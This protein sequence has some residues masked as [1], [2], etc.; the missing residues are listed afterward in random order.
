MPKKKPENCWTCRLRRKKC[1]GTVPVC[2]VCANLGIS[3][4]YSETQPE[5]MDGGSRQKAE[6]QR[7]KFEVKSR[8]SQ[9][10]KEK[11]IRRIQSELLPCSSQDEF[12]PRASLA[13]ATA[14][15]PE[16]HSQSASA[17]ENSSALWL[18]NS[19]GDYEIGLAVAFMDHAFPLL[20]PFYQPAV[21]DGSRA[22][23]LAM[24]MKDRTFRLQT[25]AI[26]S[27]LL[28]VIPCRSETI[29][30]TCK[31][32]ALEGA[33]RARDLATAHFQAD[34]AILIT[35]NIH[36]NISDTASLLINM[37]SALDLERV[38][39]DGDEWQVHLQA[40]LD[41]LRDLLRDDSGLQASS[42]PLILGQ[43]SDASI[44]VGSNMWSVEQAAFRFSVAK[45]V[46][47][48]IVASS[49]L[50]RPPSLLS[51][52]QELLR[53]DRDL[54][55]RNP[56]N[57]ADVNGCQNW[58]M[59]LLGEVVALGAWKKE[60]AHTRYGVRL[61]LRA[62]ELRKRL[63]SGL[64]QLDQSPASPT[65]L[66][67]DT[68]TARSSP[69]TSLVTKLWAYATLALLY[70]IVEGWQPASDQVQEVISRAINVLKD[71][72]LF[73]MH[74]RA[75]AWPLF[76]VGCLASDEERIFYRNLTEKMGALADFGPIQLTRR[77][78]YKIWTEKA[79]S[80][81][82]VVCFESIGHK[83]FFA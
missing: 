72:L 8:A 80:I 23:L 40:A 7:Q 83:V 24:M 13:A 74:L 79:R 37:A 64:S 30:N 38:L 29:T 58:A 20:F 22:W 2:R 46:V 81:D 32:Y 15:A 5:W 6:A 42:W 62:E 68:I 53:G 54:K 70:T 26:T 28:S 76:I 52:H 18:P 73:P 47:F 21:L 78:W 59:C 61:N 34:L 27:Y 69:S 71:M 57:L 4:L 11:I 25:N 67:L 51:H 14:Q 17:A 19:N 50:E 41:L 31:L 48:D 45:L 36:D 75:Q 3:C 12:H 65:T 60:Q 39:A 55:D 16:R 56:L 10:R 44:P 9:K 82:L 35:R 1:D 43:L 66:T 77:I 49:S 63:E 33:Q